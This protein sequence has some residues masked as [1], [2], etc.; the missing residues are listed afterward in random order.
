M[1][2]AM[3]LCVAL[4]PA[5]RAALA[6]PLHRRAPVGAAVGAE[7]KM[8]KW[9]WSHTHTLRGRVFDARR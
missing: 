4:V 5:L 8:G 9:G 3:R 1:L 7:L 6:S 2:A